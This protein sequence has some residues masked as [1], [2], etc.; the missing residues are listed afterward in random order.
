[1]IWDNKEYYNNLDYLLKIS[2]VHMICD[3]KGYYINF[4]SLGRSRNLLIFSSCFG[5][6]FIFQ[7]RLPHLPPLHEDKLYGKYDGIFF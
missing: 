7:R 2:K 5:K 3:Y 6:K 1:M 4:G